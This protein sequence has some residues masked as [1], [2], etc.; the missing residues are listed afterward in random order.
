MKYSLWLSTSKCRLL[1][2]LYLFFNQNQAILANLLL[3]RKDLISI[4]FPKR[5]IQNNKKDNKIK[6]KETKIKKK[7]KLFEKT[8]EFRE[9]IL[10]SL[11]LYWEPGSDDHHSNSTTT[12]HHQV[13]H[14]Q[15]CK[16]NLHDTFKSSYKYIL[17][18]FVF[19]LF[20]YCVII[21]CQL[22]IHYTLLSWN[23]KKY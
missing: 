7:Q 2:N 23:F 9:A 5:S 18:Y 20:L 13:D 22:I 21:C 16:P 11:L 1:G 10:P 4:N 19:I 8:K 12:E 6:I 14:V 17:L 15:C 3:K